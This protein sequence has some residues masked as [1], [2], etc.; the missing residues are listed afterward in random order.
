MHS[1][2]KLREAKWKLRKEHNLALAFGAPI[3]GKRGFVLNGSVDYVAS[4]QALGWVWDSAAPWRRLNVVALNDTIAV[5]AMVANLYRPD[6]AQAGI[7]DG[8]YAFDLRFSPDATIEIA[9][10]TQESQYKIPLN[11]DHFSQP[12]IEELKDIV[13]SPRN[14]TSK[15][16]SLPRTIDCIRLDHNNNLRCVYC[17]NERSEHLIDLSELRELLNTGILWTIL[18]CRIWY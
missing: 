13:I 5:S 17:H 7:G 15:K 10:Q 18:E 12:H 3:P 6:I 4:H 11:I 1:L 16:A 8:H 2:W 14:F 9:V